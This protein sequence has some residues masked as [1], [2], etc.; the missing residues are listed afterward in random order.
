MGGE[1][2]ST[3]KNLLIISTG[4]V[5]LDKFKSSPIK[6]VILL[7]S[8]SNFHV[9]I[10]YKFHKLQ[11]FLSYHFFN[12]SLYVDI[13]QLQYDKS[14]E[15]SKISQAKFAFVPPFN[16]IW[17]TF[18][19]LMLLLIFFPF[20]FLFQVLILPDLTPVLVSWLVC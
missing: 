14:I 10:L 17:K 1:P 18:L 12:F 16:A 2:Y 8:N 4:K 5:S 3:A 13:Q 7:S 11:S 15:W 19:L 20:L 9:I 6:S